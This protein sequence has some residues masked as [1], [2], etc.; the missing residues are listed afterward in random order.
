MF[1]LKISEGMLLLGAIVFL[2]ICMISA[3]C[4]FQDICTHEGTKNFL[5]VV[6]Y[7][8]ALICAGSM[9]AIYKKFIK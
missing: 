3:T 2:S 7:V 9:V 5:E 8:S 6:F 4:V 1:G